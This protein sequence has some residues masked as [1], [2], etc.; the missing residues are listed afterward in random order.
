MKRSTLILLL[1]AVALGSAVYYVVRKDKAENTGRDS[2][3]ASKPAFNFKA[4]DVSALALTR[5]G[6][7]VRIEKQADKW[8]IVE[9]IKTEADQTAVEALVGSLTSATVERTLAMTES[10]RRGAGLESPAVTVE[11]KLGGGA[12]HR[13]AL[14]KQDPTGAAAYALL[15][16]KPDVALVSTSLL[17][18]AD[19][20]L[21]DLRDKTIIN[22]SRDDLTR[23][24]IKN[25]H[26]K[27]VA[28]KNAEGKWLV[29]EPA[30]KKDKEAPSDKLFAFETARATEVLDS[31]PADVAAKFASPPV[32]VR[33]LGKQ[34]QTTVLELSA[35]DG[36]NI[37]ARVAGRAAVYKAN[38]QLLEDLSFKPADVAP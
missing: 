10:L 3:E 12:R 26:L 8:Q 2:D 1:V 20:S 5:G 19:K 14:G 17:T 27:L 11:V 18:S 4:E 35:A 24:E 9:P 32:V 23:V 6:R 37:Y 34:G 29:R 38:R 7:T 33:L 30:D 28:E 31:P 15:D 16:Q 21:D 25:P 13:V 36:D 22:V